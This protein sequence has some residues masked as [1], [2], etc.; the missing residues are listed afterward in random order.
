MWSLSLT[1][2]LRQ[3]G[4]K[5]ESLSAGVIRPCGEAAAFGP[6]DGDVYGRDAVTLGKQF[7]QKPPFS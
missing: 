2:S 4:R 5:A 1:V 3:T 7:G 6:L